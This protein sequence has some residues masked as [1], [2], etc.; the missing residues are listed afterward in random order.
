[1]IRT[2]D[3]VVCVLLL[4]DTPQLAAAARMAL[5]A[6]TRVRLVEAPQL[7]NEALPVLKAVVPDIIL[8]PLPGRPLRELQTIET[9]MAYRPTPIVAVGP[10]ADAL[11]SPGAAAMAQQAKQ[12]GALA[13]ISAPPAALGLDER[14][15]FI[16]HILLLASVP[17]VKHLQGVR[18]DGW[19]SETTSRLRVPAA[20]R[21]P[22]PAS[23][24]SRAPAVALVG[25]TG[26]PPALASILEALPADFG[27]GIVIVQHLAPGFA[28]HLTSWLAH[29]SKLHVRLAE[30][31][32]VLS[33]G[34]VLVAPYDHHLVVDSRERWTLSQTP[35]EEGSRPSATVLLRSMA[36]VYG[37]RAIGVVLS[38][39]GEDG[40]QGL[41]DLQRAGGHTLSQNAATSVI[42]GMAKRARELGAVEQE[43]PLTEIPRELLRWATSQR[44]EGET[45]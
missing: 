5:M 14:E 20:L 8:I 24:T 42:Y 18:R 23:L 36:R 26:G 28:T 15:A 10:P 6:D 31:D 13:N 17:V 44:P 3:R 11:P 43:L 16:Q 33:P 38:G 12:R 1:M 2:S 40:A 4:T 25:S 37:R 19:G 9:I 35:P 34:L 29:V 30:P 39:M 45:P 22:A 27:A 21:N 7:G 32:D 41:L